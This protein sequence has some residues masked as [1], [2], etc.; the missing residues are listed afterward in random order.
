MVDGSVRFSKNQNAFAHFFF[1]LPPFE[2]CLPP[3]VFD[4][5]IHFLRLLMKE[6]GKD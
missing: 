4:Q 2:M 5:N 6:S 1:C 3:K